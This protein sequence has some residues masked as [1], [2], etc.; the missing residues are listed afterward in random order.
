MNLFAERIAAI[1]ISLSLSLVSVI[2]APF[3]ESEDALP[4]F[5]LNRCPRTDHT[6]VRVAM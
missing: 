4:I 3:R 6:Y 2:V 5:P 1:P